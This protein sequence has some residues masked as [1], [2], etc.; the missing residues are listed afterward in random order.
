[1]TTAADRDPQPVAGF[2][3]VTGPPMP[4]RPHDVLSGPEGNERLTAWAGTALL[5]GFAAEGLTILDV[6]WF[7]TWHIMI[8]F[9]LLLPVAVKISSTVYRFVRYY[10]NSPAYRHKGPPQIILRVL[11]PFLL[12]NTVAV[13]L[14]GIAVM[15]A[16]SYRHPV[17]MLHK[18]SFITWFGLTSIHVLAY[19]WRLPRLLLADLAA[20]GTSRGPAVA[21]IVVVLGAGVVGLGIAALLLPWIRS[22]VAVR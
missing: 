19:V 14:T 3:D 22:W 12:L 7:M 13:L 6:H 21:R 2:P 16:G 18:A 1:V 11:A 10:T 15:F 5:L 8:G 4:G 9:A 17:E 20:R